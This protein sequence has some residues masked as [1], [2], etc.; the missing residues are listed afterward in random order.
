MELPSVERIKDGKTVV[1]YQ[2]E[3]VQVRDIGVF[4]KL[5][6]QSF[7]IWPSLY[8]HASELDIGGAAQGVVSYVQGS[9]V[10]VWVFLCCKFGAHH[11]GCT[12]HG[13]GDSGAEQHADRQLFNGLFGRHGREDLMKIFSR[14]FNKV[15]FHSLFRFY[16]AVAI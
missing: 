2:E 15:R 1:E 11:T 7:V 16:S 5:T 8:S 10:V 12:V 9:P 4:Y 13:P 3:D 14:F 6:C